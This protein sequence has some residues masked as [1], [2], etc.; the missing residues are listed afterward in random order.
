MSKKEALDAARRLVEE[1]VDIATKAGIDTKS[2]I[3]PHCP[4]TG[5]TRDGEEDDSQPRMWCGVPV[6]VDDETTDLFEM[7]ARTQSPD[8]KP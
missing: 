3:E 7:P 8:E 4:E 6:V 2:V 1:A 5:A